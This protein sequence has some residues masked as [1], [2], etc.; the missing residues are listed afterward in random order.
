M[1]YLFKQER[2]RDIKIKATCIEQAVQE[3]NALSENMFGIR[4]GSLIFKNEQD[5]YYTNGADGRNF[6]SARVIK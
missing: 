4:W 3:F 5:G 6:V 1:K 2:I